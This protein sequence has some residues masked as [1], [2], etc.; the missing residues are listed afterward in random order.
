LHRAIEGWITPSNLVGLVRNTAPFLFAYIRERPL[1]EG[2]RLIECGDHPLAYLEILQGAERLESGALTDTELLEDYFALCLA[3]HHATVAT[4][5]PTDVDAKIRGLLWRRTRDKDSLRRM[6]TFAQ[7]AARWD[8]SRISRRATEL[9]D[10]GPVSGH[11]GEHLSVLAGALGAFLRTGNSEYAELASG[12]IEKELARQVDVFRLALTTKGCE[13]D[14]LRLAATLT[15]NAGDLDQGISFWPAGE[16]Y[17]AARGRFHRLSH[18]NAIPF[19]GTFQLAARLYKKAMATEGH[20]NYPLRAVKAL[21]QSPALLLPLGPFLEDWGATLATHPS[22]DWQ[23]RADTLAALLAGCRTIPNQRGYFR[24]IHGMT[25]SLEGRMDQV[26]RLLPSRARADWK[27]SP[28]RRNC[29][30]PRVSFESMMK[31]ILAS[32][33]AALV[34]S[35]AIQP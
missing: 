25:E 4:Y 27:D 23:A 29:G 2:A 33:I 20:R 18:E 17:D 30:V 26:V 11:D 7:R 12:T 31:K 9:G 1:P 35:S 22:L 28:I 21:R 10:Y 19:D 24:A 32:V 15:H 5:V 8:I 34:S 13:L 3:S 14:A 6:F 16:V